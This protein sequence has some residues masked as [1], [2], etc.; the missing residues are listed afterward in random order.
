MRDRTAMISVP[1]K[2]SSTTTT[3]ILALDLGKFKS[4]ACR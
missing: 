2:E 1:A 3:T 4:V